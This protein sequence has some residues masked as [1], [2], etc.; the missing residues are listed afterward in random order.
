MVLADGFSVL[1]QPFS[2]TMRRQPDNTNE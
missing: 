2:K 1:L